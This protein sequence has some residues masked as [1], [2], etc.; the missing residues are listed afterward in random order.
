[1]VP[2]L[3]TGKVDADPTTQEPTE[4]TAAVERR[5][6]RLLEL[7]RELATAADCVGQRGRACMADPAARRAPRRLSCAR[8]GGLRASDERQQLAILPGSNIGYFGPF[9]RMIFQSS[10]G[11]NWTGCNAGVSV[12]GIHAGGAIKGCPT[13]PSQYVGG[14]VRERPL[15]E[16]LESRELTVNVTAGLPSGLSHLRGFCASCRHRVRCRG[17]CTQT[18][19]V[20]TGER[21][22]N[23]LCHHRALALQKRGRRERLTPRLLAKGRPFDHGAF[24]LIEEPLDAPWPENDPH[25]FEYARVAWPSGWE[26]WPLPDEA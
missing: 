5:P 17:G 16:I 11:R 15:R 3:P 19:T 8:T 1:M 14:N 21:G 24:R 23:P 9:D 4:A 12:L 2:V 18:A 7:H 6:A 25:H 20:I 26:R 10:G 13:L 22:D